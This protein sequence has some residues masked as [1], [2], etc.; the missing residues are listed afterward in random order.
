MPISSDDRMTVHDGIQPEF[1]VALRVER[2]SAGY[3]ASL[4]IRDVSARVGRGEVVV[5]V[6]PN[7]AG[8]STFLKALAGVIAISSGRVTLGDTDVTNTPTERLARQGIGY[9][10]QV[11]DVFE[12]L[13]VRENLLMGGYL[14]GKR[15]R[16]SRIDEVAATY[17]LLERLI[18]RRVAKLSGGERKLVA[19]GRALMNRPRVL[20]LDEPSAGLAPQLSREILTEQVGRLA[21]A[22][23]AVLLVEQKAIAALEIGNWSYVLAGGRCVLSCAAPELLSRGDIGEIFLGNV[24]STDAGVNAGNRARGAWNGVQDQ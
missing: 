19:I 3:G 24:A 8:K 5:V 4:V 6:G 15:E 16:K 12:D 21:Q 1:E 11:D 7:G 17:P 9:V 14:L 18:A 20:L 22:G 13:T 10:P 23:V 2:I